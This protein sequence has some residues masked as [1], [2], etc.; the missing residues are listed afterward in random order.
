MRLKTGKLSFKPLHSA[1]LGKPQKKVIFLMAGPLR[2]Y[3]PP[4]QSLMAVGN[5]FSSSKSSKKSVF[6]LN[7]QAIKRRTFSF[8]AF[9]RHQFPDNQVCL[10][11]VAVKIISESITNNKKNRMFSY[12]FCCQLRGVES[13]ISANH[14]QYQRTW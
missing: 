8:A 9:L 13:F 12:K 5:F 4:P 10:S 2:P 6:F 1:R 14:F 3:P 7:G 11:R